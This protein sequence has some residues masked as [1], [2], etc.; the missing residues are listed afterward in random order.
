MIV[1]GAPGLEA[2]LTAPWGHD[3][4]IQRCTVNK[5][6]NFLGRAPGHLHGEL[7]EDNHDLIYAHTAAEVQARRE[8]VVKKWRV[9]PASGSAVHQGRHRTGVLVSSQATCAGG[10]RVRPGHD[11]TQPGQQRRHRPRKAETKLAGRP[12]RLSPRSATT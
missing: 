5:Y 6:R 10:A 9:A 12:F 11:L 1:D 7:T 2:A 8:A 3:L 4:R